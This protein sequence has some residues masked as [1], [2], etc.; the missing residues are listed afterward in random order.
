MRLRK[1]DLEKD[2]TAREKSLSE[3]EAELRSLREKV[4]V[5]PKELETAVAKAVEE[6]S[7]RLNWEAHSKDELLRKAFE[8]EKNV[9][10]ARIEALQQTVKEQTAR[11]TAISA[12]LEKSYGQVQDIA[13]KAIEGSSTLRA[14]GHPAA[15]VADPIRRSA[16]SEG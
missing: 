3:S 2:L 6:A 16:Q 1:E 8:G 14:F 12:Q 10:T 15:A 7:A 4:G 13:V 11:I 5:F 9:L